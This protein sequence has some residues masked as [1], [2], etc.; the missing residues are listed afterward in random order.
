MINFDHSHES[1]AA[2]AHSVL[3]RMTMSKIKNEMT[4]Q[5]IIQTASSKVLSVIRLDDSTAANAMFISR[6]VYNL[7]TQLRREELESLTSI[8]ILIREFDQ[9]D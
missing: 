7:Q 3:R 4:R 9:N 5:L 2:D 8:Q 1:S 6:D